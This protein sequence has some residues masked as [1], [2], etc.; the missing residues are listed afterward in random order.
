MAGVTGLNWKLSVDIDDGGSE[1]WQLLP[2]QRG[3]SLSFSKTDVDASSKSNAGWEDS[4]STRRSFTFSV[5][6]IWEDNN[7]A[8]NYLV[9]TNQLG[10]S[11]DF[12]V[13]VKLENSAGDVYSGS[14]TMD[15]YEL[16]AP[17]SDLVSYSISFTGRGALALTRA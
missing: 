7:S 8:L 2:Q 1:D 4:I 14:A 15:S 3:G 16:D 10:T 12:P 11:T 17:E 9:D 6:G 13:G 5:D